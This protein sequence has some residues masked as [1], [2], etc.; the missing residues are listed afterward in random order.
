MTRFT[1]DGQEYEVKSTVG[2]TVFASKVTN[3]KTGK[4]RPSKFDLDKVQPLFT[5]GEGTPTLESTEN[6]QPEPVEVG[7]DINPA[8]EV[9]P[10][11]G[12]TN[13]ETT[14]D[15]FIVLD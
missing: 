15:G 7:L 6:T 12:P 1:L 4:G 5:D 2:N 3:G 13:V 9:E 11:V 14:D 8:S 10:E